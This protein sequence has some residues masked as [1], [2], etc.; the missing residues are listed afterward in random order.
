MGNKIHNIVV[1]ASLVLATFVIV[2]DVFWWR[3]G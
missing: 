3:A 1:G 2:L